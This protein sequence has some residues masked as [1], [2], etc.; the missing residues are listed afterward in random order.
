MERPGLSTT[1]ALAVAFSP[2]ARAGVLPG[3]LTRAWHRAQERFRSPRVRETLARVLAR[4]RPRAENVG[5]N[6]QATE[7]EALGRDGVVFFPGFISAETA[8]SLRESLGKLECHDP[9][10]KALG[11]FRIEAAPTGT[12]VAEI[13]ETPT[14]LALQ[15]LALD[16]RLIEVASKYLG[17]KPYL[18]CVSAWW[19][20][21]GNDSPQ[22]AENFHRDN[23]SIRFL[24]FFLYLTDVNADCGPHKFVV[25]SQREARLL[26]RRRYTDDEVVAAFGE[27]RVL[28]IQGKAGDAFMEDTFGL[29]KGQLP[30]T[31]FRLLAQFRYSV[32]PTIFRSPIIVAGKAPGT[33][34]TSLLHSG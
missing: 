27:S 6:V 2:V 34:A 33:G 20:I 19:S 13:T 7:H 31:G 23:D 25:G 15:R 8:A 1:P 21:P 28:E 30:R 10:R 22:E 26:E 3:Y 18:D 16:P 4:F 14:L 29:H 9:W 11:N 12:H 32:T 17:C 24:K 5:A